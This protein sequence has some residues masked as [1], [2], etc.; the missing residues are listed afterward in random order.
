MALFTKCLHL[1]SP[2]P[3]PH[4]PITTKKINKPTL[5]DT[6]SLRPAGLPSSPSTNKKTSNTIRTGAW[7]PPSIKNTKSSLETTRSAGLSSRQQA[8]ASSPLKRFGPRSRKAMRETSSLKKK[9]K[10]QTTN[11]NSKEKIQV[12]RNAHSHEGT[13]HIL[14]TNSPQTTPAQQRKELRSSRLCGGTNSTRTMAERNLTT[15]SVRSLHAPKQKPPWTK[16]Q[17]REYL[18]DAAA[19]VTNAPD[20]SSSTLDQKIQQ[21]ESEVQTLDRRR[22]PPQSPST[23][24]STPQHSFNNDS[25]DS[26]EDEPETPHLQYN[27]QQQEQTHHMTPAQ[28]VDAIKHHLNNRIRHRHKHIASSAAAECSFVESLPA[29]RSVVHHPEYTHLTKQAYKF[30]LDAQVRATR[31]RDEIQKVRAAKLAERVQQ[32]QTAISLA[33]ETKEHTTK[34]KQ[35][36]ATIASYDAQIYNLQL[37]KKEIQLQKEREHHD[38]RYLRSTLEGATTRAEKLVEAHHDSNHHLHLLKWQKLHRALDQKRPKSRTKK[39]TR[40]QNR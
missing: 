38:L 1:Q 5:I 32:H 13:S 28:H 23:T 17:M 29:S 34:E 10:Q 39:S 7:T 37:K 8:I 25:M 40:K 18:A 21:I 3:S 9:K 27:Y 30:E 36:R 11:N 4:S 35:K 19:V 14:N 20:T 15:T 2:P 6:S 12:Q 31:A 26:M 22:H 33:R 24:R 16:E